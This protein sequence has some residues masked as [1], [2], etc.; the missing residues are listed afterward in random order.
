M[1]EPR[2]QVLSLPISRSLPRL[3]VN[4]NWLLR[5]AQPE[6]DCRPPLPLGEG[7]GEG[8]WS[9]AFIVLENTTLPSPRRAGAR[10][11]LSQRERRLRNRR[12]DV[13][14]RLSDSAPNRQDMGNEDMGSD[15]AR[16]RSIRCRT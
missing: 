1:C 10:H 4:A 7:W 8:L 14:T 11:F 13:A 3:G 12:E 15:K 2:A 5:D 6:L 9:S 16:A